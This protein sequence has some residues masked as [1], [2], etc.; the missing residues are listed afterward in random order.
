MTVRP[1]RTSESGS[2]VSELIA[3]VYRVVRLMF[4]ISHL[5]I[6]ARS[7]LVFQGCDSWDLVGLREREHGEID[8]QFSLT[9]FA[10][11]GND[12]IFA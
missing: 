6:V 2:P 4:E 10:F 7:S 3:A 9:T 1:L 11:I 12:G 8:C 5:A